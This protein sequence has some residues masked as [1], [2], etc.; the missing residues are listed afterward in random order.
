MVECVRSR[1]LFSARFV[2]AFDNKK[3]K[4]EIGSD[5]AQSLITTTTAKLLVLFGYKLIEYIIDTF[6]FE[7]Y[8]V[9][10]ILLAANIVI[11]YRASY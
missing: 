3:K 9:E 5:H 11:E 1:I 7:N 6:S 10:I 4:S 2:L 8:V